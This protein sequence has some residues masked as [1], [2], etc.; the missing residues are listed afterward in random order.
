MFVTTLPYRIRLD[1]QWSFDVLV[2]HV[3]EKCLSI[4]EHSHYPLQHIL[5][6]C[7]VNQS[8]VSFL[9][10]VFDFITISP[11]SNQLSLD[12]ASLEQVSLQ[13]SS[14]VAKFDLMVIFIYNPT[15]DNGRLSCHFICSNDVF[16]DSTVGRIA[17][18]F[19]CLFE[20]LFF[21]DIA[22][23]GISTCHT[24]ICKFNLILPEEV[25]EMKD[26]VFCRQSNVVDEGMSIHL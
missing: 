12:G 16:E 11:N 23:S 21:T 15:L 2:K 22:V 14:K 20:Q 5:A 6:D 24:P 13:Q 17:R 3:R 26:I 7:H 1:P 25:K 10:I 19:Q 4:L 8:N 18:R 9:E